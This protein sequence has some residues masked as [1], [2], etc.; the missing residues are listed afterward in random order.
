MC[1][2]QDAKPQ[3]L[4]VRIPGSVTLEGGAVAVVAPGVGLD[5]HLLVRQR[6]STS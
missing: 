2:A 4:K 5:D 3:A 1:E 6:K